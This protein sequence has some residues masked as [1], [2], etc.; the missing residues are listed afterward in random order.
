[1]QG[2]TMLGQNILLE[3]LEGDKI[4]L[5][6]YTS[7]GI[8][9]HKN[10]HY[11][12]FIGLL[13]R[14]SIE[15][16]HAAMRRLANPELDDEVS[17]ADD[18]SARNPRGLNGAPSSMDGRTRRSV[19]R[20]ISPPPPSSGGGG[21]PGSATLGEGQD[22]AVP[23]VS[24]RGPSSERLMSPQPLMSVDT[25]GR[26]PMSPPLLSPLGNGGAAMMMMSP[27]A[28][29]PD[30]VILEEDEHLAEVAG[31]NVSNGHHQNQD[32]PEKRTSSGQSYLA[33]T[34]LG[35]GKKGTSFQPESN[36]PPPQE[37]PAESKVPAQTADSAAMSNGK[38]SASKDGK[39][40]L[41]L[42]L[43]NPA[44][45]GKSMAEMASST[46]KGFAKM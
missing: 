35:M 36:G 32:P 16:L 24:R 5:Y 17:V 10:S 31:T 13:L 27:S 2:K 45:K 25:S 39:M 11:T 28:T 15:M 1:M 21:A 44:K 8:T 22:P 19:S 38:K 23:K 4:Q 42:S 30:M 6:A 18:L 12:Q 34:K 40:S 46:F 33:L 20:L 26:G 7:T 3:L 37:P 43:S 9:D 29:V 41:A 14:P